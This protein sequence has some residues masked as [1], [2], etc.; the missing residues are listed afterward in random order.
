MIFK[1]IEKNHIYIIQSAQYNNIT[2]VVKI[3]ARIHYN[4]MPF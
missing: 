1:L 4:N 2:I 3:T